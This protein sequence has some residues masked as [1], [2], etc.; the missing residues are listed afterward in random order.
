MY[1]VQVLQIM[2]IHD[3]TCLLWARILQHEVLRER[4]AITKALIAEASDLDSPCTH[5]QQG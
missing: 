3:L 2:V 4:D 1:S 5:P